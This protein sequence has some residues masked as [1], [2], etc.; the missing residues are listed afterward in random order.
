MLSVDGLT[1]GYGKRQQQIDGISLA[2]SAGEVL[3]LL[4]P[5]GAGKT[6]LVSL[7]T[8]QLPPRSGRVTLQGEPIRLGHKDI[9]LVPQ[10]Y[11]FYPKLSVL[12]N[13][14]YF[15]GLLGLEKSELQ[16]RVTGSLAD[17]DLGGC[18]SVRS[19]ALSGGLKR[20]LNIAI[21][22]LQKPKLL[23][24]DEPTANV[25]PHSRAFLLDAVR[26]LR[27]SGTAI[28]YTSHLL[29][30]VEAIAD[31]V[32]VMDR[33]QIIL[34][35]PLHCLLSEQHNR[36]EMK[37]DS[38]PGDALCQQIA[39][40]PTAN[41]WYQCNLDACALNLAEA[42]EAVERA[43][44]GIQQLHYG[45]RRLEEVYLKCLAGAEANP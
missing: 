35:G 1:F 18:A 19:G 14:R 5:N 15:G 28:I 26:Q 24:L 32:A 12:E 36:V 16:T 45:S 22:L 23:L 40:T 10:E 44:V 33:G 29:G 27:A 11:A 42:I 30:E 37:L 31:K 7:I 34:Q 13:L 39:L 4:G 20:R 38:T 17:T 25:D 6:T 41:Q 9:A 3:G 8:G 43:G 21:A 2:L